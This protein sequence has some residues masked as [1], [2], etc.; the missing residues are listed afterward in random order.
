MLLRKAISMII[1]M[2]M[3]SSVLM[4]G[5]TTG[6]KKGE[7]E[8][9]AKTA[10]TQKV[11]D[12]ITIFHGT[13][14]LTYKDG[15]KPEDNIYLNKIAELA[16]VKFKEVIVPAYADFKNKFT[17]MISTGNIPDI[18]HCWFPTDI[19]FHGDTGAFV[20]LSADIEKSPVLSK[21]YSKSMI[22]LM[23]DEKGKIY[24]LRS[25]PA[26]DPNAVNIRMDLIDEL[27][28]GK[29]PVT[30][31]EWYD[32]FKKEKAKY[33]DSIPYSVG[34]NISLFFR[35]YGVAVG[36]KAIEWQYKD[37]KIINGF[38]AP[39]SKDAIL[40][41][42]K[43]YEE[44]L[45]DKTFVTNKGTDYTTIKM[46]KKMIIGPNNLNSVTNSIGAYI[47]NN[48]SGA[49]VAAGPLP[50]VND[51]RV[52][53]SDVY[54][55][56]PVLGGHCVSIASSSK[57][58]DACLRLIE[59]LLSDEVDELTSWGIKGVDFTVDNGQKV[60]IKGSADMYST[61]KIYSFMFNYGSQQSA[62]ILLSNQL[63][64]VDPAVREKYAARVRDG[65]KISYDQAAKV[66]PNPVGYIQL[67]ANSQAM[68]SEAQALSSSIIIKAIVGEISMQEYEAQVADF[69]KKYQPITDEYNKKLPGVLEMLK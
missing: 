58:K 59:V 18:V 21:K 6:G 50:R 40:Y 15:I 32:V 48:V 41:H 45:L 33:P 39:M 4:T 69:L 31:E 22:N 17:L 57:Q 9:T 3:L 7:S 10:E 51:P 47:T 55:S 67:S 34:T 60:A 37:G 30:P 42:R 1:G 11:P 65:M 36:G 28:G 24:A 2:T 29:V 8:S 19:Q 5:C 52:V 14:G 13:A 35:A 53:D 25:I 44:G 68:F 54:V 43:L 46:N 26:K 66:K 27:N 61:R 56:N 62:D 23:K 38:E 20:D 49:I 63:E 12:E 16:N 64:L